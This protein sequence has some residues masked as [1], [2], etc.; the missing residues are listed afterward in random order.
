SG[1]DVRIDA[2]SVLVDRGR[3]QLEHL[4]QVF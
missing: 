1:I 4:K 3:V 2:V